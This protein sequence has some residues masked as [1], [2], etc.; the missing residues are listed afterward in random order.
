MSTIN[1][2]GASVS[3]QERELDI[4]KIKF[5]TINPRIYSRTQGQPGFAE[6]TVAEQ[7][8]EIYR[9]LC[10]QPSVEKLRREIRR[11]GGLIEPVLVR[12]DTTEVIEG[13][14]RL[15]VYRQFFDVN[16]DDKWRRIPCRIVESL[17]DRQQAAFLSQIHVR[18]K[19]TWSAYEKAHFA[20]LQYRTLGSYAKVAEV[21]GESGG[22]IRH[23]VRAIELMAANTDKELARFSY[24]D[25]LI[26]NRILDM[27]MKDDSTFRET[28]LTKVKD[29]RPSAWEFTAQELRDK[30]PTILAKPKIRRRFCDGL[31]DLDEAYQRARISR[32]QEKIRRAR[33]LIEDVERPD[34]ESLDRNHLNALGQDI[35]RLRRSTERVAD[36]VAKTLSR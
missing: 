22:T 18:G 30:L 24:Y 23:R 34:I 19:T 2:L 25:V 12:W 32:A 20:Y 35:R 13:N 4:H 15:A 8:Q 7:Q 31:I 3:Y 1:L 6:L 26:R 27:A 21:L 17:T 16:Q 28:I 11:H 14:S 9:A 10:K 29:L 36:L 33:E 5:L